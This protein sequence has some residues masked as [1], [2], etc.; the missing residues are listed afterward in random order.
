MARAKSSNSLWVGLF[1]ACLL[2]AGCGGKVSNPLGPRPPVADAGYLASPAP[3][4]IRLAGAGVVLSGSAAPGARVRLATPQGQAVFADADRQGR[5]TLDLGG[6]GELRIFGL[7]AAVAGRQMQAQGYVLVTAQGRAA[8]LRAG[9]GARRFDPARG[10]GLRTID[11]DGGGGVEISALAPPGATVILRL[12]GRQA[13][14]GR[15]DAAGHYDASL[16]GAG[17]PAPIRRGL[18]QIQVYGDGFSDTVSF[19][20][21]VAP[22]LARGPV[23]SQLTPAGLRVDWMTPGGG[24]QSTLLVH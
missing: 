7:S 24:V 22:P 16:P 14:Q 11:F 19:Q 6:V 2:M 21:S 10:S 9:A 15:A 12:D 17:A 1:A 23:R 5:W 8:L 20:L 4:A 18:H 13:A 3:L